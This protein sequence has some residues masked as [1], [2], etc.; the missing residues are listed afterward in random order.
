MDFAESLVHTIHRSYYTY[1][2]WECQARI[3][4]LF[5]S[6]PT[7]RSKGGRVASVFLSIHSCSLVSSTSFSRIIGF[8]RQLRLRVT[9]RES[10]PEN[11]LGLLAY[12]LALVLSPLYTQVWE[13]WQLEENIFWN[14]FFS[15]SATS[16]HSV[17]P[18]RTYEWYVFCFFVNWNLITSQQQG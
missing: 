11:I 13:R 18:W 10:F 3:L 12:S 17:K 1:T 6:E 15:S 7:Y 9:Y 4:Q 16:V 5:V 14:F 2:T 8:A